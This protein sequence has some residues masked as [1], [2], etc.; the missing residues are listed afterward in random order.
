MTF[1]FTANLFLE[2]I[3]P[4]MNPC[5]DF[6]EYACGGWLTKNA[7]PEEKPS[8]SNFDLMNEKLQKTLKRN[9]LGLRY[10]RWLNPLV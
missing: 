3:N 4:E 7:I 10:S 6:F 2:S 5:E 8:Q 9:V 1:S